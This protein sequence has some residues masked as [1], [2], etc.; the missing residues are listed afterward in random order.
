MKVYYSKGWAITFVMAGLI[1]I[2]LNFILFNLI[3]KMEATRTVPGVMVITVGILYFFQPYFK[4]E[5]KSLVT[6]SLLGFI[7]WRYSFDHISDLSF[8]GNKLFRNKN[9]KLKRI[10]IS[11]FV[12]DKKQWE[13]FKREV[14]GG[15][16][17]NELHE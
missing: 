10:R 4:L 2:S 8:D 5:E 14:E 9:G 11:K 7:A 12:C 17:G 3:G 15:E 16:P 1:L 13:K 6:Y